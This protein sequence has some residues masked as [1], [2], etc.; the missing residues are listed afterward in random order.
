MKAYRHRR[1]TWHDIWIRS[2]GPKDG[3]SQAPEALII[4]ESGSW[5]DAQIVP[6]S[7]SHDQSYATAVCLAFDAPKTGGGR[8]TPARGGEDETGH[9]TRQDS[10]SQESDTDA[11]NISKN[12]QG[13]GIRKF[14]SGR[15]D[16]RISNLS[17][18]AHRPLTSRRPLTRR[19]LRY[20]RPRP[21]LTERNL[22]RKISS[23]EK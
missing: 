8:R 11:G 16:L 3:M 19:L 5:K 10:H 6:I 2:R 20:V 21:R 9:S 1:L 13:Y 14:H 15:P 22:F 17:S 7:I 18:L 23:L 12:Q 4:S